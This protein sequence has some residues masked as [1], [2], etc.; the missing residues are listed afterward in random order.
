[1]EPAEKIKM[2]ESSE[3]VLIPAIE[4]KKGTETFADNVLTL[5]GGATF[6]FGVTI[7]AAPITSRLF[8][9]E[10]FGLS[11]LFR[12]GAMMLGMMSCLRYEMAIVL[13]KNDE[14]A[15]PLFALCCIALV[16][17]TTLAAI[18]TFLFGTRA[19][20]YL[21]AVEL[22]PYLCLFPIYVF[23]LGLGMPLI[24]W[25]SRNKRFKIQAGGRMLTS[26]STSLAE[27]SGGLAGFR[28]G[29]NLVVIRFFGLIISPAFLLWRLSG[30]DARF[31]I[32][33]INHGGILRS[34]KRYIKF[35]LVD[36]WSTLLNYLAMYAPIVLLTAFFSPVVCGLYAKAFYLLFLPSI[37]IGQSVGQVFL[38]ESAACKAGGKNLA[39]LVEAVFNRMITIGILPFAFFLIIGPELFGLFLGARW[40]EAGVYAQILTPD[41]FMMFL[42]G[43]I[44]NLFGTLG[45]QELKLIS[46]AVYLLMRVVILSYGGL[47]LRDVRLTLFIY[48]I[49]DVLIALWQT[50]LLMRAI[51]LSATR[52]LS[53]FIRCSG[54]A[55]PCILLMAA[56][57]WWFC[58]EAGYLVALIPVFS[59]PYVAL[60]LRHDLELRQLLTKNL[61]RVYSF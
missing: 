20:F 32:R 2:N 43:S 9:P 61:R 34:A 17:M 52:P 30:V 14:D 35:P 59:I 40:T 1:M 5:S 36:S 7:L 54:Y 8:G 57:K 29:G 15:A 44:V 55:V 18:L 27:I 25:Y 19:L 33:N 6:A 60:V 37:I 48:M 10:A 31:I 38:Q 49:A 41:L 28:T 26:F 22:K 24:H 11:E 46:S 12:S 39:G 50:S 13:P 47:L 51:K 58:L 23:L 3:K 56:M 45:K 4:V 42:M 53:H 16:A 21:G